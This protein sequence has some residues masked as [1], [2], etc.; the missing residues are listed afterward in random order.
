MIVEEINRKIYD[1]RKTGGHSQFKI[2]I[3]RIL[4]MLVKLTFNTFFNDLIEVDIVK[5]LRKEKD[6]QIISFSLQLS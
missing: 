5:S 1:S 4:N 6:N 2:A 3:E